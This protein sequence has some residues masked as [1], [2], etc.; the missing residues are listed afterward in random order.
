[1]IAQL[2]LETYNQLDVTYEGRECQSLVVNLSEKKNMGKEYTKF[3]KLWQNWFCIY[4][5]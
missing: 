5:G 4:S 3:K 1:M 2:F